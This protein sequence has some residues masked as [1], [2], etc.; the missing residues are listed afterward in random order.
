VNIPKAIAAIDPGTTQ[1]AIVLWNGKHVFHPDL[2]PNKI[3]FEYI[4]LHVSLYR[5]P[6]V[7]EQVGHYGSGMAVGKDVFETV[8]WSGRFAQFAQMHGS[9]FYRMQRQPIKAHL[10]GNARAGDPNVRQAIIDRFGVVG[11]KKNQGPLYGV[12]SHIWAALAVAVVWWDKNMED[13]A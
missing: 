1:S 5:I 4:S 8:F 2:L 10:C 7:I 13:P 3:I 11:T 6:L 12:K 9:K